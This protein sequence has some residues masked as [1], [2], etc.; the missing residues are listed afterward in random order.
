MSLTPSRARRPCWPRDGRRRRSCRLR[1]R[2]ARGPRSTAIDHALGDP[3]AQERRGAARLAVGRRPPRGPRP[4]RP[5]PRR[6]AT[7][8]RMSLLGDAAVRAAAG[9]QR[10][11]HAILRGDLPHERARKSPRRR[12]GGPGFVR[13]SIGLFALG[14]T[15]ARTP[16]ARTLSPAG[17]V[18]GAGFPRR[19][20]DFRHHLVGLDLDEAFAFASRSR[21]P[22]FSTRRG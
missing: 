19:G 8:A 10:E 15:I 17:R 3:P 4:G 21:R 12:G 9:D 6:A 22:S 16:P 2:S 5:S 11:V 20:S 7:K 13:S 18:S 14:P 1:S